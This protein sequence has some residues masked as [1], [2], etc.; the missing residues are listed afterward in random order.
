MKKWMGVIILALGVVGAQATTIETH[1][2]FD[3]YYYDV[4]EVWAEKG[5]T[6]VQA[7]TATQKSD[8]NSAIDEWDRVI[9]NAPARQIKMHVFWSSF[10]GTILGGSSSALF[11]GTSNGEQTIFTGSERAWRENNSSATTWDTY[12]RYDTD[13]GGLAWNFGSDAPAANTI[14]FRSVITHEIGHSLGWMSSY[15]TTTDKF[16]LGGYGLATYDKFLVDSAGNKPLNDGTGTPGD[17]NQLDNPVYF[18]GAAAT[19]LYGGLVPIYAP[20]PYEQGSS[21]SHLDTGTFPDA[22]MSHLI[23]VGNER[24]TLSNLE[25]SMMDD[26]GWQVIP[27]PASL[28]MITLTVSGFYGIRR[29]FLI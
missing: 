25:I 21:L 13:A 28:I 4:D 14:D 15:S 9:E 2:A 12:I 7:W 5:I 20:D 3:V 26:M 18:D 17:F 11:S 10:D 29:F 6:N 8:I 19:N 27:E 1:G 24:R 22:V 23:A 16:G